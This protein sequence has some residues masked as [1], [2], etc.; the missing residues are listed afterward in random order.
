[1]SVKFDLSGALRVARQLATAPAKIEQARVRA[2]TALARSLIPEATRDIAAEFN[3][4]PARIRKGLSVLR[5]GD[6]VELTGSGAGIGIAQAYGGKQTPQGVVVTIK[7][8]EGQV[9]FRH[10]FIAS[11]G[12]KAKATGKQA[13]ERQGKGAPRMPINRLFSQNIAGMIRDKG[14][15]ERLSEYGMKI[16]T[17]EINRQLSIL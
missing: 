8:G 1:M 17:A 12:G 6:Y 11:P 13:F 4:K 9:R 15:A 14:R 7:K 16:L 10:A 5:T 3:L 2:T